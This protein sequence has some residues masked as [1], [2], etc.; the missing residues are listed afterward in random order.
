MKRN[1]EISS[2]IILVVCLF[3][4]VSL[5][6]SEEVREILKN[7]GF[8]DG[9]YLQG[10]LNVKVPKH[11]M[12]NF[13]SKGSVILVEDSKMARSGNKC[14]KMENATIHQFPIKIE[15]G[16]TYLCR[17]WLKGE[18]TAKILIYRY[19][20]NPKEGIPTF[21]W[22]WKSLILTSQW[23]LYQ[24]KYTVANEKVDNIAFAIWGGQLAYYADDASLKVFDERSLLERI[25]TSDIEKEKEKYSRFFQ[26]SPELKEEFSF[27]LEN[28]YQR[29]DKL[30]KELSSRE[31]SPEL[32]FDLEME[33]ERLGQE[34]RKV[35]EKIKFA[36][37]LQ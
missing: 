34:Y 23:Q 37:I 16:K 35:C 5:V 12:K 15:V 14:V 27:Q 32:E 22:K 28:I 1:R 25:S 31:I 24:T 8:E 6:W 13:Q 29:V 20:K 10:G 9:L 17:I 36:E 30:K 2:I 18:G 4:F 11:W 7:P 19:S 3:V 26:I 21:G 33:F